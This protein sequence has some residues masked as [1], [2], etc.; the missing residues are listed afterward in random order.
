MNA[1]RFSMKY[2]SWNANSSLK[3]FKKIFI[4]IYASAAVERTRLI[5][6]HKKERTGTVMLRTV[7]FREPAES[8]M[9][10]PLC[11]EEEK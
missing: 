2:V 1:E 11:I 9:F 3:L 6:K 4:Y 10:T 5:L 8:A 7:Q